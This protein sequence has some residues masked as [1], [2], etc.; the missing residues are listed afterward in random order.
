MRRV[1]AVLLACAFV[2]SPAAAHVSPRVRI[3]SPQENARVNGTD[4]KV[5]LV[6]DGGDAPGLFT[7]SLDGVK[8]DATGRTG[9]TFTTLSV[10]PNGQTT[11]VVPMAEGAHELRLEQQ[12]DP[13]SVAPPPVLRHFTVVA[14][15]KGG[16]AGVLLVFGLL[17]V[18]GTVGAVVAVRRRAAS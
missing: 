11:L 7:M 2:A 13:D 4:V 16:G 5:V 1:P 9:G 8:V 17:I 3:A 12:P 6:G 10:P 14:E 18:L 15:T